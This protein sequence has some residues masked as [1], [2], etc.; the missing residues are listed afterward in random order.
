VLDDSSISD[1]SLMLYSRMEV[2]PLQ[3]AGVKGL[4]SVATLI[5]AEKLDPFLLIYVQASR[6]YRHAEIRDQSTDSSF[7]A[8]TAWSQPTRN[9]TRHA[10]S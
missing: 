7:R 3:M 1:T 10:S 6:T 5:P 9:G 8:W 4:V 2:G